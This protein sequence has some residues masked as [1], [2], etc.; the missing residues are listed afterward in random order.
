MRALLFDAFALD[1]SLLT[2]ADAPSQ[3]AVYRVQTIDPPSEKVSLLR[4]L[5]TGVMDP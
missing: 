1:H 2:F 5:G 4:V 3:K